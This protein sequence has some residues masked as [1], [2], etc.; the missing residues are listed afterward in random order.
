LNGQRRVYG[1]AGHQIQRIQLVYRVVAFAVR[2]RPV[3]DVQRLRIDIDDRGTENAPA[4]IN[5]PGIDFRL[6]Q[7]EG[8]LASDLRRDR[9]PDILFPEF[10]ATVDVERV[11]IVRHG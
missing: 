8:R 5:P 4:E 11:H 9:R 7:A 6:I 1:L 10:C 2:T 3:D